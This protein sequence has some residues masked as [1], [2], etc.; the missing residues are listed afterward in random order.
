MAVECTRRVGHERSCRKEDAGDKCDS[1]MVVACTENA[2]VNVRT[3]VSQT[4]PIHPVPPA[5]L[6][7]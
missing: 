5:I 7:A 4:A 6:M 1:Q 2:P 3:G